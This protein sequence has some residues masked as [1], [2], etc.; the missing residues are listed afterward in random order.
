MES[1]CCNQCLN[2]PTR[3]YNNIF[4]CRYHFIKSFKNCINQKKTNYQEITV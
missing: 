4:Y 1:K 2:K 3:F